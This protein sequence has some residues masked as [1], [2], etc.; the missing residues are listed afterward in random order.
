MRLFIRSSACVLAFAGLVAPAG[1][2]VVATTDNVG[3]AL[4]YLVPLGAAGLSI[5]HDDIPGLKQ[6]G[7][8]VV[9]SQGTTEVLKHVIGQPRPDGTGYGMPSG[10]ASIVFAS[11]GYVHRRYGPWEAVPFYALATVTAWERVHH[12]HH[13][14]EQVIAGAAVGLASAYFFTD[15]LPDGGRLSLGMR[16]GGP[17]LAYARSW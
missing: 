17:W 1:A 15:P 13:T 16:A 4:K 5:Y 3:D 2:Q 10:H 12:N 7:L 8:T 6:L 11:A 9:V 14:T